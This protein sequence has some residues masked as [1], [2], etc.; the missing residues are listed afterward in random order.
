MQFTPCQQLLKIRSITIR[1]LFICLPCFYLIYM[2][3]FISIEIVTGVA[4]VL[5]KNLLS[6]LPLL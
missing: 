4:A 3:I 5:V 1:Y 2:L 6:L